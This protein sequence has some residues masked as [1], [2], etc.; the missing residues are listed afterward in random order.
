MRAY[1]E[2]R[3][4]KEAEAV[5]AQ[6]NG[7]KLGGELGEQLLEAEVN[8]NERPPVSGSIDWV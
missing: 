4:R 8:P 5:E 2:G 6:L 1:W 7:Q 3:A